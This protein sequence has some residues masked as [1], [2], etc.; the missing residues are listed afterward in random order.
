[1]KILGYPAPP[2]AVACAVLL[3]VLGASAA[4]ATSQPADVL[5]GKV[6][7]CRAIHPGGARLK[8]FDE[9]ASVLARQGSAARA[10][11]RQIVQQT[12]KVASPQQTFGLSPA[13]ILAREVRAGKQPK[14]VTKISSVLAS[15]GV[16]PAGRMIYHLA[17][18]QVWRELQAD[19]DAPPVHV[20]E[21]LRI[22]RG[23]LDSYWMQTASGRGCKVERIR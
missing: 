4:S 17:N 22:Y 16:D 3:A 10:S 13:A 21:P 6:L 5:L 15:F 18:G 19:G 1:M 23:W 12:V 20:G 14:P 2:V 11:V 7:A 9:V 8:C